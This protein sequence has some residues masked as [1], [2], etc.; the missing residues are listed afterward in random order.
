M[1]ARDG[2]LIALL[3]VKSE[4]KGEKSNNMEKEKKGATVIDNHRTV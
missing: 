1:A 2:A 4:A 3:V